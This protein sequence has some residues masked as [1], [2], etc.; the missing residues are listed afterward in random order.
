MSRLSSEPRLWILRDAVFLRAQGP[1]TPDVPAA[2]HDA[3]GMEDILQAT[4]ALLA[5]L[6]GR[7]VTVRLGFP[8]TRH[9]VVPWHPRLA[10]EAEWTA[11]ALANSEEPDGQAGA[12]N[13]PNNGLKIGLNMAANPG[14]A[15][16]NRHIALTP[17]R[18][19]APRLAILGNTTLLD[20]L[21]AQC[22][23]HGVRLAAATSTFAYAMHRYRRAFPDTDCALAMHERGILT[24]ALRHGASITAIGAVAAQA[25]VS[26]QIHAM[27]RCLALSASAPV[28]ET[29]ALIGDAT[30]PD[31]HI[32]W[33]GNHLHAAGEGRPA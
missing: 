32:R 2:C 16:D 18:H 31:P 4:D 17:A 5:P 7:R 9:V 13:G 28:P 12:N 23:S 15:R 8:W 10:T 22:K 33:L 30:E 21:A 11:W 19:G 6:S 26:R 3:T 20:A 1:A 25:Q 29:V 14:D 27:L 24:C